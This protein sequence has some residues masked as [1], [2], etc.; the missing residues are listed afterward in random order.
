MTHCI[1]TPHICLQGEKRGLP[2]RVFQ[3]TFVSDSEVRALIRQISSN[4]RD[5]CHILKHSDFALKTILI[6]TL[7]CSIHLN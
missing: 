1:M 4:D 7:Y 5:V 6:D 3:S 2:E